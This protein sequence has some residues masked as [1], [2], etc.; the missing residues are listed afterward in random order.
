MFPRVAEPATNVVPATSSPQSAVTEGIATPYGLA[1]QSQKAS[2][3]AARA[4]VERGATLYRMGTTGTSQA[5]E[6]QFW[7]LENPLTPGYASRYGLPAENIANAN[8]IEAATLRPGTSFVTRSAPGIGS[9]VGGGI[10]VVVPSGGV[11]MTWFTGM[12]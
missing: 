1:K 4:D 7:S 8:F 6:A 3:L 10:E 9:N 11:Q 5:A 2:A 12:P